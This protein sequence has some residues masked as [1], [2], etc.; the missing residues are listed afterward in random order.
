MPATERQLFDRLRELEVSIETYRHAPVFTVAEA[1]ALRG[2]LPGAHTKNLFLRDKKRRLWLVVALEDRAIDL[3]ALRYAL[4]CPPLSF[5]GADELRRV[6]GVEPGSVTPFALISDAERRVTPVLDAEMM[7]A[8]ILN[9]HPLTNTATT[10]ISPAGLLAFI[11]SCGREPLLVALP[12][13]D[14]A[15]RAHDDT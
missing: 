13:P 11:R 12:A 5:A 7:Q 8:T 1:K 14:T 10:A 2:A 9:F 15:A 4:G 3:K 6:L